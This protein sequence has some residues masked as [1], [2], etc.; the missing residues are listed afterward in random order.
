M[1]NEV[2]EIEMQRQKLEQYFLSLEERRM[3]EYYGISKAE[4]LYYKQSLASKALLI[5]WGVG[6]LDVRPFEIMNI[7]RFGEDFIN[8]ILNK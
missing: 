2:Q 5:D 3:A 1:I 8:F 6:A 4:F 7:T